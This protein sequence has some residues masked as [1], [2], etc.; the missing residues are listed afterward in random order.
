M[1]PAEQTQ[2]A[3]RNLLGDLEI[4]LAA[5]E[6]LAAN[7]SADPG[8][9]SDPQIDRGARAVLAVDLHQYY[10]ALESALERVA[11]AIDGTVPSGPRSHEEL[12]RQAAHPIA[13]VRPEL[14]NPAAYSELAQ[15]LS[16][17]HFFRH[18]Y[19]VELDWKRLEE[20]RARIGRVHPSVMASFDALKEHLRASI[21]A[22]ARLPS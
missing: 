2:A 6:R 4:D 14:L 22:L 15:L 21:E 11:R 3:L 9:A 8:L 10:T 20:H 17:R 19:L 16:F 7:V 18:A 12:L 1:S 5:L 13:D